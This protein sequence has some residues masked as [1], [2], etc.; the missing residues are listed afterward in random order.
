MGEAARSP[1]RFTIQVANDVPSDLRQRLTRVR[2][3]DE[4][5]GGGWSYGTDLSYMRELVAYWRDRYDWRAQEAQL[6][7]FRQFTVPVGGIELHFIH[8]EGVGPRPFPLLLSHG[9]PGSIWEFYRILPMLTDPARFGGA[10][11]DA[12]TV[13]APSLPGY[14][15]SF[16]LNQPRLGFPE[17]ADVFA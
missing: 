9:W 2:W 3:P 8:V 16:R 13:V 5:P 12:F 11:A 15:F 1:R 4:V 17:I 7:R 10:P 14:G 6:N